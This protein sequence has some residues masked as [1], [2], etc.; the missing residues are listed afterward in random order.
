[1]NQQ[2][3]IEYDSMGAVKVPL[4]A[5]YGAQTQRA[6]ENFRISG[7]VFPRRF[8]RANKASKKSTGREQDGSLSYDRRWHSRG[9][10]QQDLGSEEN[11]RRRKTPAI[12]EH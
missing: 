7:L 9:R 4:D 5:Y 12:L 6:L 1:M 8:I 3:R 2:L 11:D 10:G